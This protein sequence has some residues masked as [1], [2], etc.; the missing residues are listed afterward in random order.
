MK[1]DICI[2]NNDISYIMD[3]DELK[4]ALQLGLI[5]EEEYSIAYETAYKI[6]DIFNNNKDA[7]YKYIWSYYNK[8]NR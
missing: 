1:L 3:D 8:F 5:N 2:P 7:Y 6:I 4:E